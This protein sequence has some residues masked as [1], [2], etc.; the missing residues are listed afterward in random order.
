MLFYIFSF[1]LFI[2]LLHTRLF[3]VYH[4]VPLVGI[5]LG[6]DQK[7]NMLRAARAGYAVQLDWA[8]LQADQLVDAV[9][10]V[11]T[12][13]AIQLTVKRASQLFR[14]AKVPS[15]IIQL[16]KVLVLRRLHWSGRCGGRST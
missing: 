14:D 5:P 15:L 11:A 9:T 7:P 2:W 4:G 6:N 1:Y 3:A 16:L 8:G 12:D 13:P 10:T